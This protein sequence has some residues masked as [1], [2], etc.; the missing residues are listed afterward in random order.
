MCSQDYCYI[1]SCFLLLRNEASRL[2]YQSGYLKVV[3]EMA[4]S[5]QLQQYNIRSVCWRVSVCVCVRDT[6]VECV[7]G[8][9]VWGVS[10]CI[11]LYC[12]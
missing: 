7:R 10:V 2:L 6:G 3:K 1:V 11:V 9:C 5:G 12:V 8:K 4:L